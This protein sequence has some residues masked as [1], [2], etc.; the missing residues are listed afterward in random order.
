MSS[1]FNIGN[2]QTTEELLSSLSRLYFN[3]NEIERIYY[4]MFIN[5]TPM[6]VE[7]QRY[8]E[9]GVL[10][11]ITLP[12]R[13]K[14]AQA[15]QT[16]TGDPTGV[17]AAPIGTFYIDT[18]NNSLYYK[19]SGSDAYGWVLIWSNL[20]LISGINYLTPTG[21]A[22]Q[23]VNLNISNVGSGILSVNR[24]GTGSSAISGI[25]KGNGTSPF[26]A[27]VDGVD[28]MG[29]DSMTGVIAYY[30]ISNIPTGWLI[31]DGAAYARNIYIKLF[32]KIGTTYGDGD[33]STTFNVPNL[34]NYYIRC[35]DGSTAF[36]TVQQDQVGIHSHGLEGSVGEESEHTHTRGSMN[37]TGWCG[38]YSGCN[39]NSGSGALYSNAHGGNAGSG[40]PACG[41]LF[42]DASRSWTGYTS[43]GSAHTHS[44]NGLSTQNNTTASGSTETRVLGKML[45]PIIK[46]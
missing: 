6:D 28:Y 5:S 36:N 16:G 44:L 2:I 4:D 40:A 13:A 10:E 18:T 41:D 29:S 34:T 15:A 20:N 30:P 8:D 25:V 33:G 35:W 23:L 24:G 45:V 39:A 21:D 9:N 19:G 12:N 32:N 7:F 11:T 27:A 38:F 14:Q 17:L 26:T 42:L 3:M 46:Y 1:N 31:C 43:G 37:I 22:S